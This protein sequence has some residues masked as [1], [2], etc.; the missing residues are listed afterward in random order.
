L[1]NHN[2]LKNKPQLAPALLSLIESNFGYEK[3]FHYKEDFAP[4]MDESNFEH[5][6]LSLSENDEIIGHV[7]VLVRKITVLENE[8]TLAMLGGIAVN[9]KFQGKGY[10]KDLINHVIKTYESQVSGFLLWSDLHEMYKKF[11]FSLCGTQFVLS[12]EVPKVVDIQKTLYSSL[13]EDEKNQIQQLY[14][15][16]F[17]KHYLTL[18]RSR[19]DWEKIEKINSAN[20]FLQRENNQIQ[21]Y[22]FQ[23]KGM[24]LQNIIYEYGH[25]EN[26]E[27]WHR[28]ISGL[29][30]VWSG[31]HDEEAEVQYQFLFRP[32]N[33]FTEFVKTYTR[34][35]IQIQKTDFEKDTV[36]LMLIDEELELTIDD[37]LTGL[38]GPG[39]FDEVNYLPPLFISGLDS[40]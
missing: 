3:P 24:D 18:D 37:F 27:K 21:G 12:S 25:K 33:K 2:T 22:F 35:M 34:E 13:S 40:I 10:F 5:C 19:D 6:H 20:L 38:L 7:G 31:V 32:A 23:N 17:Q 39:R 36:T 8:Y 28:D 14:Q 30:E 26:F 1:P 9:E 29:G 15:D 11:G 16:G 4:L